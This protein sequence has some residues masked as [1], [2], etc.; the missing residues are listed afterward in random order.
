MEGLKCL[1]QDPEIKFERVRLDLKIEEGL[2]SDFLWVHAPDGYGKSYL[3]ESFFRRNQQYDI[4]W[5]NLTE[6]DNNPENFW[7]KIIEVIGRKTPHY[8]KMMEK[9][10]FPYT[11]LGFERFIDLQIE[12]R[13]YWDN[14]VLVLDNFDLIENEILKK[15]AKRFMTLL[16]AFKI[17]GVI[18]ANEMN[19]YSS[20]VSGATR[21]SD[22][23][24]EALAFN[25]KELAMYLSIKNIPYNDRGLS[26]ILSETEGRIEQINNI[27]NQIKINKI[28]ITLASFSSNTL[29]KSFYKTIDEILENNYTHI[30]IKLLQKLSLIQELPFSLV[31]EISNNKFLSNSLR[32]P[33]P[34]ISVNA[35]ADALNINY[36]LRQRFYFL[37]DGLTE[38][39]KREVYLITAKW[40]EKHNHKFEAVE[41]YNLIKEYDEVLR[42]IYDA[43]NSLPTYTINALKGVMEGMPLELMYT[44][45]KYSMCYTMIYYLIGDMVNAFEIA[46]HAVKYFESIPVTEETS[47][48]LYTNYYLMGFIEIMDYPINNNDEAYKYF[49]KA[50]FYLKQFNHNV[51]LIENLFKMGAF[52]CRVS[53]SDENS[54]E[55]FATLVEKSEEYSVLFG[56]S[57]AGYTDIIKA[58]IE[59][60]KLKDKDIL[61]FADRGIQKAVKYYQYDM[62]IRGVYLKILFYLMEGDFEKI[63]ETFEELFTYSNELPENYQIQATSSISAYYYIKIKQDQNIPFWIKETF[64]PLKN[65]F[66]AYG[67]E[68][69]AKLKYYILIKDYPQVFIYINSLEKLRLRKYI[70]PVRISINIAKAIAFFNMEKVDDAIYSFMS[71]YHLTRELKIDLFYNSFGADLLPVLKYIYKNKIEGID[72][73]WVKEVMT[74]INHYE[75]NLNHLISSY[76][77]QNDGYSKSTPI[78]DTILE[79]LYAN[80]NF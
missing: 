63:N 38:E 57:M 58:E 4:I 77:E 55:R 23:D 17:K 67:F 41:Y 74:S 52:A 21:T 10:G 49:E 50:G 39:E 62:A 24:K 22:I 78:T 5:M 80:L 29:K 16:M 14:V 75:L 68:F 43:P 56:G 60:F 1:G 12:F 61:K 33:L 32:I 76:N 9:V 46:D 42:L 18:I 71:A 36:V 31:D 20:L 59:F 34:F 48:C 15:L 26:I 45:T 25:A 53:K 47:L 3:M 11:E 69:V 30:Q 70:L 6:Y 65:E 64:T 2:Q 35:Y 27:C 40:A 54:L 28:D 66:I 72:M 79:T 13:K 19:E 7:G 8:A 44:N 73:E 37:K 51:P